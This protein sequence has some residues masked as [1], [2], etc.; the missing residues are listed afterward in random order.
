MLNHA[1]LVLLMIQV[2]HF[3][4]LSF[5]GALNY[6]LLILEHDFLLRLAQLLRALLS[7]HLVDPKLVLEVVVERLDRL[8]RSANVVHFSPY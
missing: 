1:L 2:N 7:L 4:G 6:L 5:F 8:L 3:L